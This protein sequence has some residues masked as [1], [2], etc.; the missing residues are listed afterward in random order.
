M[1]SKDEFWKEMDVLIPKMRKAVRSALTK[2]IATIDHDLAHQ[3]KER[4][5]IRNS[6]GFLRKKW[7]LELIYMIDLLEVPFYTDIHHHLPEI[8][9]KTLVSRLKEL[10][11]LGMVQRIVINTQPIRVQYKL[12]DFGEGIFELIIPL[13]T[14]YSENINH[15]KKEVIKNKKSE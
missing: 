7:I 10:E 4:A 3:S 1:S 8:N 2:D 13:L 14:F 12:T 5:Q 11:E 6:L 15:N 9:T